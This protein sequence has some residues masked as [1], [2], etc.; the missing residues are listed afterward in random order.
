[1]N[2]RFGWE[3]RESFTKK[4]I[5]FGTLVKGSFEMSHSDTG[6]GPES[7]LELTGLRSTRGRKLEG[8]CTLRLNQQVYRLTLGTRTDTLVL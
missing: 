5:G 8:R 4:S 1:M 3:L 7:M 6:T 2:V